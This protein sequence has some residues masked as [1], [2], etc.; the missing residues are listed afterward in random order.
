MGCPAPIAY[1]TPLGPEQ[2]DATANTSGA[3]A[4]TPR[5]G[6][7]LPVGDGQSLTVVFTPADNVS[8]STATMSV[9]I[10]V[11]RATPTLTWSNPATIVYGTPLGATQLDA[12]AD[13][14]GTFAYTPASGTVLAAGSGQIL[15]V[16][17]TPT[18]SVDYSSD[19]DKRNDQRREGHAGGQLVESG[20]HHVRHCLGTRATGCNGQRARCVRV[21]ARRRNGA[22]RR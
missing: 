3:F 22:L 19:H 9:S 10:N 13:V 12:T 2:L 7:V 4:Y 21:H 1:G 16:S 20:S 5:S 18:D 6:T 14:P 17:F 11:V 8:Y 15:T